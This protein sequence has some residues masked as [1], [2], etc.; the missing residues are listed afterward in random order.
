MFAIKPGDDIEN[1]DD[2]TH[3]DYYAYSLLNE[4][5]QRWDFIEQAESYM[6][7][8]PVGTEYEPEEEKQ[9]EGL[10]ELREISQTNWAKLIVSAT[11]DRLGILGFRSALSS[12]ET[13]DEVVERLFERDSMGI[14]AQE[15]MTLACAYRSAYLY[16]DPGSKRQKVLPP[17]NAAV[18]TDVFGEPVAAVVLLR[19]RVLSR[20]VLNLFVRET[21]EDTGEATGRCHMFVA[22]R[23]F[24]DKQQQSQVARGFSLRLTQYDSEVPFNRYGV[25]QDWV[26]WKER[27]VDQE[28]VPVTAITNK[29]GKNEFEDHF[30]IIDR[31]NHM[32]LQR[33][34]IAT[35]QAFRQRGVKGNFRRRDEF[36]QEID[37][38]DMFEASPAALWML[39][40]GAE[41]WE[42]SPTSFQEI[43]NSV[44]KDIQDLASVT[45]TPMSYFSDSLNQSA[46]GA[47]AQKE[48]SIAKVEDRR[49]RFGAAWKRHI[50][51]LLGVN[52]EKDR[53]EEDSLEVIWGPI[54]TYTLS[55]KTAAVTSLVGAGVSL[56]TALREGAFMTPSE[57]RR[58]ENERIEE[59]LS[60]TLTSAIGTMTPLAKA[61][62]TQATN[63][64][65]A[66]SESQKQQD[67][68]A[69][70]AEAGAE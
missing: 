10:Q 37:Y 27:I 8:D 46:Q 23:E 24:D 26:W 61:K 5:K 36:G 28:R 52:G 47:N 1:T 60:Q 42:S 51:I 35:M 29:D 21:D 58:A 19:D 18:M 59:M 43:L 3:P 7:G 4:I 44:S 53:A 70:K 15:A 38:S 65:P 50:S 33:T 13:G 31:I 66:K 2:V 41:I 62:A 64:T 45:Y 34:V 16:V 12:G 68:L 9:F 25:M 17:S 30:S 40:E 32:T 48:N 57:I 22:T 56:R 20:D 69:G 63:L 49:R 67:Q 14:K 6:S 11:T 39:P 54:Q 55:E